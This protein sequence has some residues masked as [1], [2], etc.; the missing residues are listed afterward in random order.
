MQ[1]PFTGPWLLAPMEG[2]TEPCFRELVLERNP[3]D[4][5]GGAFTEFVRVVSE[6]LPAKT[7]RKHLGPR[8][9][10]QPVGLQLMGADL[11][12]LAETARRA[13][14]EG[15]PL[16]DLNFGCPAKGAL[17]GCSGSDLLRD[18][19]RLEQTVKA[20]KEAVESIPVTAKIRAGYDHA[21]D[22][23]ILARAAE[24]GGADL[25]TVHCRTRAEFYAE[26]VE[27]ERIARA[28]RAVS[29]PVC[30][31]GGVRTHTDLER[32]RAE[33]GCSYVMVGQAALGDPWIFSGRSVGAAQAA[34]FLVAYAELAGRTVR[35]AARA[36]DGAAQATPG[37]LDRRR[38]VED[39]ER[40][41]WLSER[42]PER[43]L[44][45]LRAA[46]TA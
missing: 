3:P 8:R 16:L 28:V 45:R 46:M 35:N 27:W 32:M 1:L 33:T 31:N 13:E 18:P 21:N 38:L 10:P 39:E 43:T 2:V 17:R 42:D 6:A 15:A 41:E 11:A 37:S 9:F 7:L 23:E 44:V 34:D 22:V 20:V 24:A 30:G 26:E 14:E 12:A 5:L 36:G 40:G 29:I 19:V 4:T 25:L